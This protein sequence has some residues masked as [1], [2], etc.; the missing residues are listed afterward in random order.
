MSVKPTRVQKICTLWTHDDNFSREDVIFNGDKFPELPATPG[1][2]MQIIALSHAPSI[3]DFQATAKNN[4]DGTN[5]KIEDTIKDTF[6]ENH[7]RRSRRGSIKITLDENGVVING[8]RDV[9]LEKSYVFVAKPVSAD[10]KSKYPNL[11]V[12]L[13]T[14]PKSEPRLS[15]IRRCPLP[16]ELL[17]SLASATGFRSWLRR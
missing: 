15:S 16:R 8:G 4:K 9:D 13:N 7:S 10:L 17:K 2:L 3:R 6:S 5:V 14:S 1:S 11:Q 12:S